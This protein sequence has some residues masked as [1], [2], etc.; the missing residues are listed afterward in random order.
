MRVYQRKLSILVVGLMLL[1]GTGV[2]WAGKSKK[3]DDRQRA[4]HALNRLTFGVRP[5]DVDR[6]LAIGIDKWIDQQLQP[7]R[8]DDTALDGRLSQFRTLKMSTREI[9]EKFPPPQL[10]KA[11]AQGRAPLPSDPVQ[12]AVYESQISRMQEK[13]AT[14]NDGAT[15]DTSMGRRETRQFAAAKFDELVDLPANKRMEA[16]LK[17]SPGERR[18]FVQG[19]TQQQRLKLFESF[20]PE[21]REQLLALRSPQ[22]VVVTELQQAKILRAAYSE[23]QLEEVMTDFWFN[24]FNVFIGKGPER[25]LTTS[26]ERDVI[27]PYAMGKFKDLLVAT[28][29]S[30]AMLWYLDNCQSVGP[31]SDFARYGPERLER[32]AG[33]ARRR[34]PQLTPQ[35]VEQIKKNMPKGLNENYARELMELHTLG[36][37][38]GYTQKDVTEVAKVFTGWTIKQ[39]RRGGGYEF[40]ERR[41]EPGS[42]YVLG[43]TIKHSGE[44]EGITVLDMLAHHPSTA[45]F[46]SK[47]LAIRFVSDDPPETLV[48]RMADTFLKTDGNIREVLRTMFRS[49]E[50]WSPD[51]YRAK[52]K[53][54][55]EFVVS[56]IRATGADVETALPVIQTLNKM[57][58]PLYGQQPPTGY[59]MKAEAWVNSAALL[60]RMNFGLAMAAGRQPGVAFDPQQL[61]STDTA[62]PGASLWQLERVLLSGEVSDQTHSTI[63]KQ[64]EDPKFTRTEALNTPTSSTRVIT[65][66]ILG[67]PEFQRR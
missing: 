7:E 28:A 25:Y 34:R 48:D 1:T 31:D 22:L 56:S 24:H 18:E 67:S 27:R 23:H 41:H 6:V 54:L 52:V 40:D 64:M 36:V 3:L 32:M 53:T 15:P 11:V 8:I 39:P 50:F 14:A 20:S 46:I 13:Q 57:G 59:P 26:Y 55:F 63:M 38:G 62:D 9:V 30:P 47:K 16:I 58:M 66:L 42:K 21:Q 33:Y 17:M 35:R 37:D 51:I 45:R 44:K 12:R 5:G 60:N 43:K 19:L 49:E 29:K 4:I 2:L 65:G 61:T 10:V